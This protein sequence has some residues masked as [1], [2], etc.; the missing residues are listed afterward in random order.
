MTNKLRFLLTA[1][2]VTMGVMAVPAF[3]Q[4]GSSADEPAKAEEIVVTGSRIKQD[5]T[6]SALPLQIIGQQELLREGINSPEQLGFV[7][8]A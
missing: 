6:K 5:P 1:S 3:A 7:D 2:I 4:D 8:K